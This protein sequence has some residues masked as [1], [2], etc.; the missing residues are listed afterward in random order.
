[1][2]SRAPYYSAPMTSPLRKI[3]VALS[4]RLDEFLIA[5]YAH[6]VYE[7]ARQRK[8]L[9]LTA[10]TLARFVL[11]DRSTDEVRSCSLRTA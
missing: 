7:Y 6:S 5:L 8:L 9:P 1:M 2:T 4:E 10:P 11:V 3:L